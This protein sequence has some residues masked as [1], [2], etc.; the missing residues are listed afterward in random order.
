MAF[1]RRTG[2]RTRLCREERSRR[3]WGDFAENAGQCVPYRGQ[4]SWRRCPREARGPGPGDLE[5]PGCPVRLVG[6]GERARTRG[7]SRVGSSQTELETREPIPSWPI[8][9]QSTG[10]VPVPITHLGL[11]DCGAVESGGDRGPR[12]A[13][14]TARTRED[15][16]HIPIFRHEARALHAQPAAKETASW[17]FLAKLAPRGIRKPGRPEARVLRI[18]KNS[19]GLCRYAPSVGPWLDGPTWIEPKVAERLRPPVPR[20]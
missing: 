6:P 9:R 12:S 8:R 10:F 2:S 11:D 1:C 16:S 14:L 3:S 15:S 18:G 5:P 7:G 20:P 19:R 13:K 4:N 17:Y